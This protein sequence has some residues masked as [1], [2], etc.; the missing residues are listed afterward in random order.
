MVHTNYYNLLRKMLNIMSRDH[1]YCCLS[2]SYNFTEIIFHASLRKCTFPFILITNKFKDRTGQ[3]NVL[4][5]VRG[6]V[7]SF[8]RYFVKCHLKLE[9]KKISRIKSG[10]FGQTAKFG[11]P[12]SLFHS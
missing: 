5:P 6:H 8:T 11:Q 9:N 7:Q 12:P 2:C 3:V 1:L 4:Y 10:I